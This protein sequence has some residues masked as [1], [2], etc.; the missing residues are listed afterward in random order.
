MFFLTPCKA[1]EF[2]SRMVNNST[3]EDETHLFPNQPF[4]TTEAAEIKAQHRKR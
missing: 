3:K 1:S 2:T 4:Q